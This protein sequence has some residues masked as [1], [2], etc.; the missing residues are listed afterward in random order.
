[1]LL[2]L[3]LSAVIPFVYAVP[4]CGLVPPKHSNVD[5]QVL[6]TSQAGAQEVLEAAWYPGWL[7][8]DFPPEKISWSK[9]NVMNF[10]FAY[11]VSFQSNV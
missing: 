5:A 6:N 1:M 11:G 10:A 3:I 2:L 8:D 9:Y 4:F 7:A